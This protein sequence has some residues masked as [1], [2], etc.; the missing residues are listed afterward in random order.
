MNSVAR[1]LLQSSGLYQPLQSWRDHFRAQKL[2]K[3]FVSPGD[4]C[5]DVG[6]HTGEIS[7]VLNELGA[8][9]VAIEPEPSSVSK[10]EKRLGKYRA[11]S[12]IVSAALGAARGTADLMICTSTDCCSLS[13]S[14]VAAVRGS[15]RLSGDKYHWDRAE[16]VAVE[17]LDSLIE[18]FGTPSFIKIDVEG[19]EHEV[20][21]GLSIAVN[22]VMFE[23]T[24]EFL[25]PALNS[26]SH[27][28]SLGSYRFN[29]HLGRSSHLALGSWLE[30]DQFLSLLRNHHFA[31]TQGP[32]GDIFAQLA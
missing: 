8:Y 23:F 22:Q 1:T 20:L 24:P 9:T 25:E 26:I 31:V 18:R 13:T 15:G 30:A 6:A 2:L 4:L 29:Y 11:K 28:S 14:F 17:T 16:T 3:N 21:K 27:L 7:E 10:L 5:F 19:F 32:A 12:V